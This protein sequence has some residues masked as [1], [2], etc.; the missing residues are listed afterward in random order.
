MTARLPA[1]LLCA[2]LGT[3]CAVP[4]SVVSQ[5]SAAGP[6]IEVR[7]VALAPFARGTLRAAD[8]EQD[9]VDLI[10]SRVFE[11]L[12]EFTDWELVPPEEIDRWLEREQISTD[13]SGAS[14]I[15]P[16]AARAFA[17]DA[18]LYGSVRRYRSRLG[19]PRG[20]RRPASVWFELEL[21][22]PDG[23]RLW[24]GT[25][26]EEQAAV[27]DNLLALPRAASRGFQWVDASRLALEG[28][29]ELIGALAREQRA[30]K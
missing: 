3:A 27:S 7:K 25:Y 12:A 24:R 15:G 6:G 20:S 16:E 23:T 11:A 22:L 26:R 5:R 28:A 30:W 17:A 14:E 8:V 10:R 18:V 1:L 2:L 13:G 9:G 19:G 21:K 29:R 4:S